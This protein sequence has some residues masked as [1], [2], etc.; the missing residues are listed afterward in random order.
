MSRPPIMAPP[1]ISAEDVVSFCDFFY[2][3]TGISMDASRRY[4]IDRRLE[5]RMA[6]NECRNFREYLALVKF[7]P[8]GAEMQALIN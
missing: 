3:K 5:E 4:F 2:K 7:Q 8:G 6:A 1:K